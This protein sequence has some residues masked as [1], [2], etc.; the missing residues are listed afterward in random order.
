M[1]RGD[2]K[3][4]E[5]LLSC[6]LNGLWPLE[7]EKVG[8]PFLSVCRLSIFIRQIISENPGPIIVKFRMFIRN[9]M[10]MVKR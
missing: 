9:I 10:Q 4:L 6:F 8:S 5:S 3:D 1:S 7:Y 2:D